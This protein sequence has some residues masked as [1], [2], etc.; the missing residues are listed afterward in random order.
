M[1]NTL[2]TKEYDAAIKTNQGELSA[3]TGNNLQG[4]LSEK[5]RSRGLKNKKVGGRTIVIV[6][7]YHKHINV[8]ERNHI[9]W[10]NRI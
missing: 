5:N 9:H 4:L 7:L 6:E 1:L 8:G 2:H 10:R 3:E